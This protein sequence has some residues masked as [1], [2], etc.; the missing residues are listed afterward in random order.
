[1]VKL[2][3]LSYSSAR[4]KGLKLVQLKLV[5]IYSLVEKNKHLNLQE[6]LDESLGGLNNSAAPARDLVSTCCVITNG[7]QTHVLKIS[8]CNFDIMRAQT[9]DNFSIVRDQIQYCK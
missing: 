5:Q 8:D 1:L 2:T 4:I 3:K 6:S 9:V 7:Q